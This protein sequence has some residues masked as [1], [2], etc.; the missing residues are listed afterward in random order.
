MKER[1]WSWSLEVRERRGKVVS[2]IV[3]GEGARSRVVVVVGGGRGSRAVVVIGGCGH[4]D[5]RKWGMG[6][7]WCCRHVIVVG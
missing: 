6:L 7:G 2:V 5:V 3:G 1:E 4:G